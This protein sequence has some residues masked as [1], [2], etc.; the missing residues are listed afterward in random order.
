MSEYF[1]EWLIDTYAISAEGQ[2]QKCPE[3]TTLLEHRSSKAGFELRSSNTTVAF[4][5]AR[6][7]WFSL[8]DAGSNGIPKSLCSISQPGKWKFWSPDSTDFMSGAMRSFV[9][10]S[11]TCSLDLGI[12]VFA[13]HPKIM[14]REIYKLLEPPRTAEIEGIWEQYVRLTHSRDDLAVRDF[15]L[16]LDLH[17]I[18]L[19]KHQ[20]EFLVHKEKE[21]IID[22]AGMK[23]LL[24]KGF[25]N[26]PLISEHTIEATLGRIPND[27]AVYVMG[28]AN[29]DADSI[30]TSGFEAV[31]RDLVYPQRICLP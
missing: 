8:L 31:R 15:L 11:G 21:M 16:G 18:T 6:P 29:P 28:H 5:I 10:S 9:M 25:D 12:P 22:L 1:A 23:P 30:V 19:T 24:Q 3:N 13:R 4:P 7:G 2:I 17:K 27:E 14:I 26:L 20:D